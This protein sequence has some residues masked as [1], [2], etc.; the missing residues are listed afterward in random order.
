MPLK[1]ATQ[2]VLHSITAAGVQSP[3]AGYLTAG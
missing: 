1:C 2:P 3:A